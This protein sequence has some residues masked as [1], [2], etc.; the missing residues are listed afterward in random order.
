V[1]V[2]LSSAGEVNTLRTALVPR[3][4]WRIDDLRFRFN[5]SL[6]LPD[7]ADE[8]TE[9]ATLVHHHPDA[10]LSIFAHADPVG[11][12]AYN[13]QLSGRRA[14]VLY[15]LLIRDA[16]LWEQIYAH[17]LSGGG[18]A[19]GNEEVRLMLGATGYAGGAG[20][21]A[22]D[23][24]DR[25][26]LHRFQ[27][28][29][30]LPAG[31]TADGPTR[32]KLFLAYMDAVCRDA[33]G[34]PFRLEK[35]D[36]LARGQDAGGKGDYQGCGEHNPRLLFSH[37]EAQAYQA[38]ADK[39]AR[40]ADNAPN[41]RVVIY[42][43]RPGVQ[44]TPDHWPC[45]RADEDDHGCRARLWSD[46]AQ[47]HSFQARRRTYEADRDTFS[48]RFYD[49][50]VREAPCDRREV[51]AGECIPTL[52]T[53]ETPGATNTVRLHD[54]WVYV[55]HFRD[56][57]GTLDQVRRCRLAEGRL[58]EP[59]GGGVVALDCERPAW[60]YF[61]HRGDLLALD[62]GRWFARDGSG[63]P[64]LGP[65]TLPRGSGGRL[66]VDIWQQHDWAIV[67]G[68]RVDG[69]RP[70]GVKMAEWREDYEPGRV[71][72]R[73]NGE[74]GYFPY[75]DHREKERQERWKGGAPIDLVSWGNPGGDPMWIGTLSALP[76]DKAKLLLVHD[77]PHGPLNAGSFNEVAPTGANQEWHG[78]HLYDAQR[79]ALLNALPSSDQPHGAVDALPSPPGRCLLPGDICWASQGQTNNCGPYSFAA[80]MNYWMPYTNNPARKDG[81]L[82]AQPG[83]VDDTIGGAR[84]PADIV[85]AAHRFHMHGRDNDAEELDRGRAL[86]LV[87]LWLQAGVPVLILVEEEYNLWSLHW[88]TVVGYDGNRFFMNNSGA[89]NELV[90][91]NRTPGIDYEHTPVGNDVDSATAFWRKWKA[92]GGDVVDLITSVD[93]CTF[94][95]L[96]PTDPMFAAAEVR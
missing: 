2:A 47:R 13:K 66:E 41:R 12:D 15:G 92:A 77:T 80:A 83:N 11:S 46:H 7:A 32:E 5:S 44:V 27:T 84:T 23:T 56:A 29:H 59:S 49:R 31:D 96:Y 22:L 81:A 65:F 40:N 78:H 10:P 91:S 53:P 38:A 58:A 30:G 61:S 37:A 55:V 90:R 54:L 87:K 25:E 62:H 69:S 74:L 35:R 57:D 88:K 85:N 67:H 19:W 1:P 95:P 94:I 14:T 52:F 79:V 50:L 93:E 16:A 82:Y 45:P 70:D 72:V 48:C 63:L 26:A 17:P 3:A 60:L 34:H 6:L 33:D 4:C 71:L 51:I 21:D 64:L 36:F 68:P 24:A 20:G 18:D 86:K 9:L 39:T 42:L 76:T 28:D 89:D 8:L 73:S 43:F 75:G